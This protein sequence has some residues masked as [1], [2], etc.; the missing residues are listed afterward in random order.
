MRGQLLRKPGESP[1]R[2]PGP[3]RVIMPCLRGRFQGHR[4][5]A[6][7]K[8]LVP[9]E[10]VEHDDG[11]ADLDAC[12]GETLPFRVPDTQVVHQVVDDLSVSAENQ[13]VM[14]A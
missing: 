4:L 10:R 8:D 9:F 5:K 11:Q 7:V 3:P 1:G 13:P 14:S 12:Q 6:V 2:D